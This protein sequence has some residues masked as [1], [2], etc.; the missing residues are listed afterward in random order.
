MQQVI[1][2]LPDAIYQSVESQAKSKG[3]SIE[4]Y[5]VDVI[6][7]LIIK[8]KG[9]SVPHPPGNSEETVESSRF[10]VAT[11]LPELPRTSLDW[12]QQ[13]VDVALSYTGVKAFLSNREGRRIGF[14]PNFVYVDNIY[15]EQFDGF[16]A[17]FGCSV[18]MYK[19]D[20]RI[21]MEKGWYPNWSKL[22]VKSPEQLN[23][24]IRCLHI[25][26]NVQGLERREH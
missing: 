16:V 24:A 13:F 6:A 25:A 15:I 9:S 14:D 23:L 22:R 2:K 17:S 12:V 1:L 20:Y 18:E 4:D 7:E 26:A 10:D 21:D 5:L 11:H 8:G 3:H 19:N